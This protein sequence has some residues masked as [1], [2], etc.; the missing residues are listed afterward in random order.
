LNDKFSVNEAVIYVFA[1]QSL[2]L[3]DYLKLCRI[4]W[5]LY[6][7]KKIS[8]QV[9]TLIFAHDF[10]YKNQL[11]NNY[12]NKEVVSLLNQII[13]DRNTSPGVRRIIIDILDG[14]E[15]NKI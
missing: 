6:A 1:M 5:K 11:G 14:N 13:K 4:Y 12:N 7:E 8:E 15:R 2:P 9:F 3:K 10:L